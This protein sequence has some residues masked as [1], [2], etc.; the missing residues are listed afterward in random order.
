M[1]SPKSPYETLLRKAGCVLSSGKKAQGN[2]SQF[3]ASIDNPQ[4]N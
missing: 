1:F 2:K 3:L 4:R